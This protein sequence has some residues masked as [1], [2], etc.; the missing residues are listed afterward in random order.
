MEDLINNGKDYELLCLAYLKAMDN[1]FE[2]EEALVLAKKARSKKPGSCT[3][4][5]ITALIEA[6]IIPK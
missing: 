2:V 4:N 3:F 5:I 6:Q 1:Y